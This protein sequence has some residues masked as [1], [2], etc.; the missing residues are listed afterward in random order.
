MFL[1]SFLSGQGIHL[2][3]VLVVAIEIIFVVIEIIL[4]IE[5]L[6]LLVVNSEFYV[7]IGF[8]L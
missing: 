3:H 8:S 2:L 5:I 7:A 1:F 4:A 6:L